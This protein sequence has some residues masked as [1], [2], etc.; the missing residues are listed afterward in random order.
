MTDTT[1]STAAL[2]VPYKSLPSLND[3]FDQLDRELQ[4]I[5]DSV[6]A[7]YQ[8]ED[9][10]IEFLDN[11][12]DYDSISSV[13][14]KESEENNDTSPY[15]KEKEVELDKQDIMSGKQS[16]K[17]KKGKLRERLRW[18]AARSKLSLRNI[19]PR[20]NLKNMK[21]GLQRSKERMSSAFSPRRTRRGSYQW[22][23]RL[24]T[25]GPNVR[26]SII[27]AT[28]DVQGAV[29]ELKKIT[30]NSHETTVRNNSMRSTGSYSKKKNTKRLGKTSGKEPGSQG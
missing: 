8:Q 3:Q 2:Q 1:N 22:S 13:L 26:D 25:D 21:E 14:Y 12:L 30:I 9:K 28:D 24:N 20:D 6:N 7:L 16:W 19:G 23:M 5:S 10:E 17:V 4:S 11:F 15:F 29:S 27:E 18:L